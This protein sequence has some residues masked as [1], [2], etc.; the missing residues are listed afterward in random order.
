[1]WNFDSQVIQEGNRCRSHTKDIIDVHSH[2]IDAY[3]VI[4]LHHLSDDDFSAD[5]VS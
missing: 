1:M 4:L 3:G 5:A 2:A